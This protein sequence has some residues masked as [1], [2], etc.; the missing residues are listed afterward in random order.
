ME[1]LQLL[2]EFFSQYG[3]IA[4]FGVLILCG[5][6]LPIP[7]DITLVSGGIISALGNT[8]QHIMFLVGMLGVL[9]GDTFVFSSGRIFGERILSNKFVARIMTPKRY[10]QVQDKFVKYDKWVIFMARFMPG[11]RMPV[12]LSAGIS[13]KVGLLRFIVTDFL[14]AIISV[15]IWIYLGY[16]GAHN[17][18]LLLD[19]VR[20]GQMAI[21]FIIF[22]VLSVIT[23]IY[24]IK[25]KR[26]SEIIEE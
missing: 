11:L 7:E 20:H 8:N 3:Y 25:K 18:E 21:L 22:L 26:N 17:F 5:F 10:K 16:Y 6:G 19:W 12:Y 15:P 2:V 14:A 1:I 4:V 23:L 9:M 13:Q 24:F